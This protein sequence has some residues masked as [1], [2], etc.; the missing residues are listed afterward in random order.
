[1]VQRQVSIRKPENAGDLQAASCRE[2]RAN[3]IYAVKERSKNNRTEHPSI[4]QAQ[5]SFGG[6]AG[7]WKAASIADSRCVALTSASTT[8]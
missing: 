4:R 7:G 2:A 6:Q 3:P 5:I 1:L 8:D